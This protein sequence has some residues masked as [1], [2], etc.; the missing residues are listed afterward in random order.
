MRV[1]DYLARLDCASRSEPSA[2]NLR[3]LQRAHLERVP[4]ENLDIHLG[5]PIVLDLP[6]LHDKI[7]RRRRGGFC[8][9]LNGLFAW[10]LGEL[11]YSVTLLSGRVS[12][13]ERLGPEFDHM[14]L[15]V[16]CEGRWL[17]DVGFGDSFLEPLLLE[18]AREV[19][20]PW[21]RYWLEERAGVWRVVRLRDGV[22]SSQYEFT[23]APRRLEDF[24][25]MC[26]H[27]Q[28]SPDSHFTRQVTCSRAML[29]HGRLTY[30]GGRLI[31]TVHARRY[32]LPITRW[33][34]LEHVLRNRFGIE[35]GSA[36]A[37]KRLLAK[38]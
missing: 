14:A 5:R 19:G 38:G 22:S 13:G 9:E 8:Y 32:E 30:S 16:E 34:D 6:S 15:L 20:Q 36:E 21:S 33:A 23:L 3:V 2:E 18:P 35:L 12:D 10:L 24:A 7:V 4:F 25:A 29:P 27:H 28:T 17:V 37:V 26:R 11:G 31:L 1:E